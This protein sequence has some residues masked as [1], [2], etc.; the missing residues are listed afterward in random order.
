METSGWW[1][2]KKWILS[3]GKAAVVLEPE[4]LKTEI[5]NDLTAALQGY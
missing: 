3:F 2:V 1:D 4:K 5:K